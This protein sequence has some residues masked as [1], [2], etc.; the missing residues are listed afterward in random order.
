MFDD[1]LQ[2]PLLFGLFA[3]LTV[4]VVLTWVMPEKIIRV[5]TRFF[6]FFVYRIKIHH[7]ENLPKKGGALLVANHVS[8]IDGILM[9]LSSARPIRLIGYSDYVNNWKVRWI[10]KIFHVIP[11]KGDGGPK[12]LLRSL[13]AAREAVKNGEL[14]CIFAEGEVTRT[15]QLQPFQRG[16]LRIVQGTNTPV[17]PVF[18]G[19]LWGS[20]FSFFGGKLFWK[21]P[22]RWPYPVSISYGKPIDK[23]D[24][25][26]RVRLAV[27]ELGA[28]T[29]EREINREQIPQRR[30]LR[31]CKSKLFRRKIADSS[32]AELTGGKLLTATLLFRKLLQKNGI[33]DSQEMVGILLP[34]SAGGVIANTSLSLLGKVTVNLNYTM[35]EDVLDFCI[36]QC[37]IKY[38]LTSRRFLE[39]KPYQLN[40]KFLYLEDLKEQIGTLQKI[41]AALQ[42]YLLPTWLLER[43]LK[44]TTINPDNLFTII[45]TSGSTGVPKGVMLTHHNVMSNM[46]G[47]D[48]A[49]HLTDKDVLLGVL[50][51]FHSFGFTGT[52]W[53]PLVFDPEAV[54]HFN[55]LDARQ[56]G[57]LCKKYGATITMTTPTFMR[58]YIKRC[59]EEEL[60]E[61]DLTIVGAEK[62][63]IQLA[64]AFQEKFG[65]MPTEGYGTT[66]LSPVGAANVPDHRSGSKEQSGYKLGTVGRPFPGVVAKVVN[67]ETREDLGIEKEG[68]LLMKGPN[69]MKGYLNMPEKTAEV[70]QDG[71]YNTGDFAKI[72]AEGFI[73]ITGRQSRFSKIGGEMV[74]HL[75][76]EEALLEVAN[77]S[78]DDE[79][80]PALLAVTAVPHET[81]GERIVVINRPLSKPV[82][83]I[84][85]ELSQRGL[86]NLWLPSADS[87]I[88]VEEV[89]V[90]G[91]GKLDL[92]AVKQIAEDHFCK[93]Q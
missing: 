11:I 59:K 31:K 83:E 40:A 86:P 36:E 60:A 13:E 76:I 50:P 15:G 32:G 24:D 74:P 3:V 57:K 61:M 29:M 23:P 84:L 88:E 16:L 1:F 14:V 58:T 87:F 45:F 10:T 5:L 43:M 8:W 2:S 35:T 66:E 47:V 65:V 33:D 20:V 26:N 70:I 18:L 27:E 78:N 34:P 39:K 90:L 54:Y 38:V 46:S 12:A 28:E 19:G 64:H 68:L 81:K 6:C 79:D 21:V 69:V 55:P 93:E 89:P 7:R 82:A 72:D 30:F 53:L 85:K 9:L 73:E 37:H 71:W 63:P 48:Q 80:A 25:V 67:P 17:I 22:R 91:T 49:F 75:K 51:F 77:H 92:K 42:T 41:T 62:L 44:L 52:L 56:I 4:G